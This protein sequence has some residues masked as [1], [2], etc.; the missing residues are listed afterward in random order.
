MREGARMTQNFGAL[1]LTVLALAACAPAQ[2]PAAANPTPDAARAETFS[3]CVW[4]E[5]QSAGVSVWSFA[6]P[7]DRLVAD[8]ALPGFVREM[9]APEGVMRA[10]V[11]VLFTKAETEPL[12]AVLLAV[13]AASPGAATAACEFEE[14][15]DM[16]G[17]YRFMPTG[18][19]RAAYDGLIGGSETEA[20]EPDYMPCGVWG[21]SESGQRLFTVVRGAEDRVAAINLGSDVTI[22]DASTLRASE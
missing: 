9:E 13:R 8:P 1:A 21:P 19:A 17:H 10:P 11:I 2:S 20:A 14:M 12:N 7:N 4:G 5:V 6:C 16:V 3:N 15:A 18:E 22:F